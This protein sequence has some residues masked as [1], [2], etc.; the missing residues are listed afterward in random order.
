[1]ERERNFHVKLRTPIGSAISKAGEPVSASVISPELFLGA[2]LTGVVE[3]VSTNGVTL[4][5]RTLEYKGRTFEV[6]S[7]TT[8]FVN[9]KGH[10]AKDDE[11]RPAAVEGGA[12]V[13]G[14]GPFRLDEG[15]EIRLRVAARR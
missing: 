2:T 4:A 12:F 11:D 8:N 3:R 10:G 5:F 9:S 13:S 15:A 7:V 14:S 1:V 6:T